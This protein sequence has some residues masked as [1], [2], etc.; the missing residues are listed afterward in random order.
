VNQQKQ[1]FVPGP[2]PRGA[3]MPGGGVRGYDHVA[4]EGSLKISR[5]SF[6]EGKGNDVCRS[7][8]PEIPAIEAGDL[9]IVHD[10]D[11]DFGILTSQDA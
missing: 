4:Q 11:A 10:H 3:G 6:L 2:D 8:A 7:W 5:L 1:D 9:G